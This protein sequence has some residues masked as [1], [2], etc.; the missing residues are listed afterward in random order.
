MA[1][2]LSARTPL[3]HDSH[4][5]D[6]GSRRPTLSLVA[7]VALGF[8]RGSEP[9]EMRNEAFRAASVWPASSWPEA[10]R[11]I[12]SRA[13]NHRHTCLR[14]P[15]EG[16]RQVCGRFCVLPCPPLTRLPARYFSVD[17][18]CYLSVAQ[19]YEIVWKT[20]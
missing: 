14:P 13:E 3:R 11:R 8:G 1:S 18:A 12:S 7:A 4:Q 5:T 6:E 2:V 10:Q 20:P 9:E 17:G 19:V 15:L 16:V